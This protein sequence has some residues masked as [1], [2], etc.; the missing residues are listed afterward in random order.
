MKRACTLSS[1]SHFFP[2]FAIRGLS[3]LFGVKALPPLL[4]SVTNYTSTSI[5]HGESNLLDLQQIA[6]HGVYGLQIN[7]LLL[8]SMPEGRLGASQEALQDLRQPVS[9]AN[10]QFEARNP[11]SSRL[12]LPIIGLGSL[13]QDQ[14]LGFNEGVR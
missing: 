13:P 2:L 8:E 11:I 4:K 12:S 10:P 6:C 5:H 7:K 9:T 3:A 14:I 1:L